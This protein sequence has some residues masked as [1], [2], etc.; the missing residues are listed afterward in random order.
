MFETTDPTRAPAMPGTASCLS[1]DEQ[2][3]L[4]LLETDWRQMCSGQV[5]PDHAQLDPHALHD[6]LPHA[7]LLHRTA[8][9]AVRVRVAG[10]RLHDML[11]MDPR[12][13]SFG[14]FFA[15]G[16]RD[17]ALRIVESAFDGPAV[18]NLPLTA[19]RGLGRRALRAELLL[20]PMQDALGQVTRMMGALVAAGPPGQRGYRFDIANDGP[21]RHDTLGLPFPDRRTVRSQPVARARTP[22]RLVVN[23]G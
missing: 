1:P 9:G 16:S 4:H 10:Q 5:V 3:I 22:L 12:G 17:A 11:R 18:V 6:A 13:M 8:P 20:L 15:A 21:L 23:N 2:A 19:A 14:A 7:F